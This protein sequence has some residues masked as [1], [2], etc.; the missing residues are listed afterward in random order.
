MKHAAAVTLAIAL[1]AGLWAQE[2]ASRQSH[3]SITAGDLEVVIADNAEYEG[4]R[5]WYNG[6]AYLSHKAQPGNHFWRRVAGM[7]FEHIWD[8]EKWW[9]PAEVLFEPRSSE[10]VLHQLNETSVQLH[11]PPS[12]LHW[13]ESW[14]TYTVAAPHYIDMDFFCIPRRD[15]FDRGYIGLFWASYIN[16]T[17]E[18]EKTIYYIGSHKDSRKRQWVSWKTAAHSTNGTVRY[19]EDIR[20][21]SFNPEHRRM[22]YTT[23]ADSAY[24]YP[25]YYGRRGEMVHIIMFE[26]AP[27][28]IRFSHSPTSGAPVRP[29][30]NPAWDWQY[31]IHDYEVGHS[32]GYTARLVYKPW[33]GRQDVIDEYESWSGRKV[34]LTD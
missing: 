8:G 11:M 14:T 29:G 2:E 16:T 25:F 32:Y 21:I 31:I 12:N 15:T 7:N 33:V 4:H 30:T 1:T 23:F 5:A 3:V 18:D 9:E 24:A 28:A 34:T 27:G 6:V 20:D 13:L 22:L 17:D 26:S 10:V 19:Q